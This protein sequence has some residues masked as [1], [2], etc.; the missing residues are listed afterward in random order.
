MKNTLKSLLAL[1]I[2]VL[3]FVTNE[4]PAQASRE[5]APANTLLWKISGNGLQ[6]PSYLFGTYHM[7]C[8][9]DFIIRDKV[10]KALESADAFVLETD[11]IHPAALQQVQLS[12]LS[13]T[14]QTKRLSK[15]TWNEVDTILKQQLGVGL[16]RFDRFKLNAISM[17]MLI[18]AYDCKSLKFFEQELFKLADARHIPMDTLESIDAQISFLNNAM[19]DEAALNGIRTFAQ[20]KPIVRTSINQYKNEELQALYNTM[21][22]SN[23]MAANELYWILHVRNSNWAK[24]MPAM[25]KKGSNFFAVG[26]GHLPGDDGVIKLLQAQGYKVEP[27]FN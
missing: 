8:E 21:T 4:T 11:V 6:K 23:Q 14:P 10:K 1:T 9:N 26:A 27:V 3:A 2:I 18:A 25:M 24:K 5:K 17:S 20:Y 12:F 7:L 19:P 16:D 22:Q 13:D 15:E